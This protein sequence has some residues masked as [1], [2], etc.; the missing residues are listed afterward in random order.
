MSAAAHPYPD[1]FVVSDGAEILIH[2]QRQ[3][4]ALNVYARA[5][6]ER[7]RE[8]VRFRAPELARRDL[9]VPA[10]VKVTL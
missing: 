9:R 3:S 5:L 6:R 7:G 1:E 2:T 10:A 4:E 8:S